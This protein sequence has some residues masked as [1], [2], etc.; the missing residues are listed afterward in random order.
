MSDSRKWKYFRWSPIVAVA[1]MMGATV[2]S[3]WLNWAA[4][5]ASD[6]SD[7]FDHLRFIDADGTT[8]EL[9]YLRLM[10]FNDQQAI[11][12]HHDAHTMSVVA[13]TLFLVTVFLAM[14]V[15]IHG[16]IRESAR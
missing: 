4:T 12:W 3:L 8:A 14:I 10:A 1:G 11:R 6:K 16:L 13:A 2:A 5:Q 15:G 9:R 7:H